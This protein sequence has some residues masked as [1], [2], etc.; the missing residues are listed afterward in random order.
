MEQESKAHTWLGALIILVVLGMIVF[1]AFIAIKYF[2]PET[3][4]ALIAGLVPSIIYWSVQRRKE[5]KERENWIL[6]D[7]KAYLL[8]IVNILNSILISQEGEG[9]KQRKLKKRVESFRPALLTWGSAPMIK[10]WN[11]LTNMTNDSTEIIQN[12]EKLLRAIRKD[13]GHN[14]SSLKPGDVMAILVQSEEKE[15]VYEA[16]KDD[17][18]H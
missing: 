2:Q 7:K 4:L 8:E 1:V 15:K 17:K 13:L 14:D 6:R 5:R 12:G 18:Y 11:E 3:L 9:I 16:C 10:I